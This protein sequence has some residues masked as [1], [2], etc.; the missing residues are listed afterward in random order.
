M[1]ADNHALQHKQSYVSWGLCIELEKC[2][3]E[4]TFY[5]KSA[6]VFYT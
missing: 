4:V 2:L 3:F 1:E 6:F 5:A